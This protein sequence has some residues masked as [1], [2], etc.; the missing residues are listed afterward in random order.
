MTDKPGE[1][2]PIGTIYQPDEAPLVLASD[3]IVALHAALEQSDVPSKLLFDGFVVAPM[4]A[5]QRTVSTVVG[6]FVK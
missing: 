5:M 6:W 1:I 2:Y 4:G 3:D